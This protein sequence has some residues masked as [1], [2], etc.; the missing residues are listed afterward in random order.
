MAQWGAPVGCVDG[1]SFELDETQVVKPDVV[2]F[3]SAVVSAASWQVCV[4]VRVK[5]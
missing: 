5:M 1:V 2:L 3:N 4:R